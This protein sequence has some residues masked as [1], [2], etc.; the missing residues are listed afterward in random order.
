MRNLWSKDARALLKGKWK[1]GA[2]ELALGL[3]TGLRD[4]LEFQCIMQTVRVLRAIAA[5]MTG[6]R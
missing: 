4:D 5:K 3:V 2:P 6:F 1:V